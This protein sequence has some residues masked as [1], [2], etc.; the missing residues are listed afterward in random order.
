[1]LAIANFDKL[2]L[3]ETDTSK[4]GLGGSIITKQSDGQ[5]H[6]V[7]YVNKSLITYEHNYHSTKQ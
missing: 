2:F 6:P 5:Y 1:M 4:S 7:A 3:L